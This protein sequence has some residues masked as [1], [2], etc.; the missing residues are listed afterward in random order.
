MRNHERQTVRTRRRDKQ[1]GHRGRHEKTEGT[2]L[3]GPSVV[4][5]ICSPPKIDLLMY[6]PC[7]H[8]KSFT[9]S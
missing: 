7:L 5:K 4:E 2:N 3:S 1:I 8:N 6:N 9:H